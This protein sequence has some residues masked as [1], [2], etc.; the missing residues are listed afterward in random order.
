MMQRRIQRFFAAMAFLAAGLAAPP[1]LAQKAKPKPKTF[2]FLG[3]KVTP[4]NGTYLVLQ[5]ANVRAKPRT[6]GRRI[7]RRDRGERVRVVGRAKGPWLAIRGDDGKDVGF[8]YQPTLMPVIDDALEQP[9]KAETP[10]KG[11]RACKYVLSFE[12][13]SPA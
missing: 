13:K 6:K 9:I 3:A 5:A 2:D 8:I 4:L 7:G 12:G 1:G 10:G 11:G